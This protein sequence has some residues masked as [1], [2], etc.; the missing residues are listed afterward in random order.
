MSSEQQ[1]VNDYE[2]EPGKP[3]GK[4]DAPNDNSEPST[5]NPVSASDKVQADIKSLRDEY[6]QDGGMMSDAQSKYNE[7]KDEQP[8]KQSDSTPYQGVRGNPNSHPYLEVVDGKMEPGNT[9]G[10][11]N[12]EITDNYNKI[13]GV[14][15]EANSK[16]NLSSDTRSGNDQSGKQL[17]DNYGQN[18][19]TLKDSPA[20]HERSD[21]G[22]SKY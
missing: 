10:P 14:D 1:P 11:K 17:Q 6:G 3:E 20:T 5:L 22:E 19:D 16:D 7:L 13:L 18:T 2:N 4:I 8:N 15:S 12:E 9:I 21:M